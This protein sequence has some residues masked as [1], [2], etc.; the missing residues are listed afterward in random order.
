MRYLNQLEPDALVAGFVEHP[1]V[2]FG[3][4]EAAQT[5]AF[6]APFDLLTTAEP[7]VRQKVTGA[8]GYR[9]WGRLLRWRTAFVGTTVSEYAL[10]P[11]DADATALPGRLAQALGREQRM[12]IVKDIPQDSPLLSPAERSWSTRFAD[13]CQEAGYVLLEGQALAYVPI[14]FASEDEYLA[15]LSSGRRKDIR[16]KLRKR[17]DVTVETVHCGDPRFADDAVIDAYYALYENVYAQSEIHFDKL[18]REFFVRILRDGSH[19]GVVFVYRV[20]SKM[21]GWN[22]CFV[23][24]GKLIDKYVGFAYPQAREQNLYFTSWFRNLEYARERGLT[25]YVAGWTDPQVKSYLGAKFTLTRHAIYLRNP[26]L[27]AVARRLGH[28]F[29]SDSQ[30][31]T[32]VD[33]QA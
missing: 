18:S 6:V 7:A 8:P 19:G 30:W 32:N 24:D 15:R 12:L 26:L 3:V 2:G 14:D 28:L 33:D 4:R 5:P 11:A 29:E 25:H 27:R 10:F 16:R 13:A 22:L 23:V 1:P 21:I 9:W 17:D 20:D 31:G